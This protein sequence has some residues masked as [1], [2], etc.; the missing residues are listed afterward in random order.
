MQNTEAEAYNVGV[1]DSKK[2]TN[3]KSEINFRIFLDK[4]LL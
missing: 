4:Q 1:N 3:E 2:S